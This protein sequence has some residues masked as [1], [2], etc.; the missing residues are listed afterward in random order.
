MSTTNTPASDDFVLVPREPTEAMKLAGQDVFDTGWPSTSK[1]Y[2][3]MLAAAPASHE[4]ALGTAEDRAWD[5][6]CARLQRDPKTSEE[7]DT[8]TLRAAWKAMLAFAGSSSPEPA[9][10]E[11]PGRGGETDEEA[12]ERIVAEYRDDRTSIALAAIAWARANPR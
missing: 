10:K 6:L 8:C 3:A 12:A 7:S 5:L 1:V 11:A 4:P 2:S 9:S